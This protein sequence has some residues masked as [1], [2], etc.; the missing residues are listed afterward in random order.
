LGAWLLSLIRL[1]LK[2]ACAVAPDE[3][4]AIHRMLLG[5]VLGT[6]AGCG[7]MYFGFLL[8]TMK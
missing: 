7:M 6:L 8:F 2:P 1:A 3:F 5:G 4:W